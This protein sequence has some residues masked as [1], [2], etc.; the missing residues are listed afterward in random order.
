MFQNHIPQK[1]PRYNYPKAVDIKQHGLFQLP[2]ELPKINWNEVKKYRSAEYATNTLQNLSKT[3][4]LL[5][6]YMVAQSFAKNEPMKRHL[7][8]P[9]NMPPAIIETLHIDPY[10]KDNFGEWTSENL[11]F[12]FIRLFILTNPTDS[13]NN[14]SV[15][16]DVLKFSVAIL[17]DSSKIIGGAFNTIISSQEEQLRKSDPF[18]EAVFSSDKP[19]F[20]LI[21]SQEH[22]AIKALK[23]KYA[24]FQIS[25]EDGRVGLHFMVARSPELRT[26]DTFELVAASAEAFKKAEFKYMVTCASNEWT[27]AA[28]EVLNGTQVHFIPYRFKQRVPKEAYASQVEP[29]SSDGFISDKDSGAMFYVLKLDE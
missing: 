3:Q 15:N 23:N 20:D 28:C 12:W 22:D 18:L 10:G 9:K 8:P 5:M 7:R 6:A 26:E 17:D 19:I 29:Y 16:Q 13:I 11:V 14:I 24:D 21:F 27:G 1:L 4:I 25:L 2:K